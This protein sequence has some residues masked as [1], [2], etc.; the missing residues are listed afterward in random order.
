[1]WVSETSGPLPE[2]SGFFPNCGVYKAL[3]SEGT[4]SRHDATRRRRW[5]TIKRR[6]ATRG[7]Y[8]NDSSKQQR[9]SNLGSKG[10]REEGEAVKDVRKEL[11]DQLEE[12]ENV[13]EGRKDESEGAKDVHEEYKEEGEPTKEAH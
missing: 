3:Q 1:M 6:S 7:A 11:V 4:L 10:S 12:A 9:G 13:N 8:R 5:E 2:V